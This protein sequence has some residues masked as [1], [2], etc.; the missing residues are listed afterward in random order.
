MIEV[1]TNW[2]GSINSTAGWDSGDKNNNTLFSYGTGAADAVLTRYITVR[3]GGNGMNGVE[4]SPWAGMG[5]LAATAV[6]FADEGSD[7]LCSAT[8]TGSAT[9][10]GRVMFNDVTTTT[11]RVRANSNGP[12]GTDTAGGELLKCKVVSAE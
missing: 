4:L 11:I 7:V 2:D 1:D 5:G 9:V 10:S 8:T 12:G 6:L 3:T